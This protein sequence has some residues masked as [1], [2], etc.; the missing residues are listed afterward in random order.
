MDIGLID[1]MHDLFVNL[2]G[3]VIFSIIG[4]FYIKRKG[5]GK[6]ASRFIPKNKSKTVFSNEERGLNLIA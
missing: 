6:V 4:Y 5:T 3:A 2:I 1:T